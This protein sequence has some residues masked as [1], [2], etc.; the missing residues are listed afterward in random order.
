M[1]NVHIGKFWITK[2]KEKTLV[3]SKR[4]SARLGHMKDHEGSGVRTA[5]DA[6]GLHSN[7]ED[8]GTRKSSFSLEFHNQIIIPM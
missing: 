4:E 3:T 1:K 7:P 2:D 6:G 8:N 5:S